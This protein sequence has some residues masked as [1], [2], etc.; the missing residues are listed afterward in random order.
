MRWQTNFSLN[1]KTPL[2][3]NIEKSYTE[4][5]FPKLYK[6]NQ[7]ILPEDVPHRILQ[8]F[9]KDASGR[10]ILPLTNH[11][12]PVMA[13]PGDHKPNLLTTTFPSLIEH[14]KNT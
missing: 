2:V 1:K 6:Y 10:A 14:I 8:T 9:D 12:G 13:S 11:G 4:S 7:I 3:Q 5:V